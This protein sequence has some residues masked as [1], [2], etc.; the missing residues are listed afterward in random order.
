MSPTKTTEKAAP[1]PDEIAAAFQADVLKA[2]ENYQA[3]TVATARAWTEAFSEVAPN[4]PEVPDEV[5]SAYGDPV[6]LADSNYD[7]AAK[8]L[9][10][11]KRFAHDLA[12]VGTSVAKAEA[13]AAK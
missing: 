10:L 13:P 1:K 11:N 3:A 4:L 9:E 6:A 5:R 12:A 7:F 8:V 2:I